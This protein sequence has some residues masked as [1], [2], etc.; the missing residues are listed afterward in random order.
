VLVWGLAERP[1]PPARH[2]TRAEV[3]KLLRDTKLDEQMKGLGQ[4]DDWVAGKR[5]VS[6]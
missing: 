3:E 6:K 2:Q 4:W 1:E 5:G